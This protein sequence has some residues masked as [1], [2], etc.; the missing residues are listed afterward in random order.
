M[1][2]LKGDR[3]STAYK[4]KELRFQRDSGYC[5]IIV[6]IGAILQNGMCYMNAVCLFP[7]VQ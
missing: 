6:R 3:V 1:A 4:D 2:P 5:C 7:R